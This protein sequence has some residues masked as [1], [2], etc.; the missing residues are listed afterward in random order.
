[1]QLNSFHAGIAPHENMK[2][3]PVLSERRKHETWEITLYEHEDGFVII[4]SEQVQ[5]LSPWALSQNTLKHVAHWN[6]RFVAQLRS[7]LYT[8]HSGDVPL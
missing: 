2:P 5:C 1:M 3:L 8:Q 7:T 4:K 6:P